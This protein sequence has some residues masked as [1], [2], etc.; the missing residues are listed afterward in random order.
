MRGIPV[1]SIDLAPE[2]SVGAH[3]VGDPGRPQGWLLHDSEAALAYDA[4][5]FS[6]TAPGMGH[7]QPFARA[8]CMALLLAAAPADARRYDVDYLVRFR[9]ENEAARV[10]VAIAPDDGRATR[11]DFAMD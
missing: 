9:P 4:R 7:L 10:T 5:P 1:R 8:A 2:C 3:P 6:C 11:L